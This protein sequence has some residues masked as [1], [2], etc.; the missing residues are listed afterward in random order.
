MN[1][2]ANLT[3]GRVCTNSLMSWDGG[4]KDVNWQQDKTIYI[5]E[6]PLAVQSS[7]SLQCEPAVQTV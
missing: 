7:W 5:Q 4:P 2:K 1:N 3:V 6:C